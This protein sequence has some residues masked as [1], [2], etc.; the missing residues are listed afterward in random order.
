MKYLRK[1]SG[2]SLVEVIVATAILLIG[3]LAVSSLLL[4]GLKGMHT[5]NR[6]DVL[7]IPK[8]T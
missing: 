7:M 2:F 4:R 1:K 5:R 6:S 8:R 3:I